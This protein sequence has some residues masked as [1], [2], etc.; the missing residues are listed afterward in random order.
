MELFSEAERKK[1]H[2]AVARLLY[3]PKRARPD[4]MMVVAFL[5]T[6]VTRSMTEDHQKLKRVLGYLKTMENYMLQF[7]GGSMVFGALRKQ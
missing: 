1:F 3:L 5:C 7:L 4:I 6:R 2:T